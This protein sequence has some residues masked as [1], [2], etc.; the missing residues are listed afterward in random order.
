VNSVI[1]K[2]HETEGVDAFLPLWSSRPDLNDPYHIDT[3]VYLAFCYGN[4]TE[5]LRL[6]GLGV[7]LDD[8]PLPRRPVR[9]RKRLLIVMA[10]WCASVWRVCLHGIMACIDKER[11]VLKRITLKDWL[12][13]RGQAV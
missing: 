7:K 1:R 13:C 11:R 10:D 9:Q 2:L 4:Q 5:R 6:Y 3:P 8:K 12:N